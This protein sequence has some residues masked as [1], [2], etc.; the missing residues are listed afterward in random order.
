MSE[1]FWMEYNEI[2][3]QGHDITGHTVDQKEFGKQS[4]LIQQ[5]KKK[6]Q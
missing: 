3:V 4:C 6:K 5:K 2:F 1:K